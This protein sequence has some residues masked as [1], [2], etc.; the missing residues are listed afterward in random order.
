MTDNAGKARK[1]HNVLVLDAYVLVWRCESTT[2]SHV[3]GTRIGGY[4]EHRRGRSAQ[5]RAE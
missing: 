2:Q 1:R 5:Q 3:G 4:A